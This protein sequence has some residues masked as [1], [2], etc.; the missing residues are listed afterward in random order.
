M[1]RTEEPWEHSFTKSPYDT[2]QHHELERNG[3]DSS[4]TEKGS[5]GTIPKNTL[6][7]GVTW[8]EET[9]QMPLIPNT[10]KWK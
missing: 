5:N 10:G 8:R 9:N 7:N 3:P 2:G 4:G 1:G 6:K